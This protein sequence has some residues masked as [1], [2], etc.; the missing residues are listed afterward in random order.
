MDLRLSRCFLC[1]SMKEAKKKLGVN[2][3]LDKKHYEIME[4]P[5]HIKLSRLTQTVYQFIT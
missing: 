2:V 4:I 3:N 5:Q 1:M